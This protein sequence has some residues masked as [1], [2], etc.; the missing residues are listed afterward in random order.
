MFD[1]TNKIT[2]KNECLASRGYFVGDLMR[3][4]MARTFQMQGERCRTMLF[5][6]DIKNACVGWPVAP[7]ATRYRSAL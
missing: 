7:F 4:L 6:F 3:G 1:K 5:V 2:K